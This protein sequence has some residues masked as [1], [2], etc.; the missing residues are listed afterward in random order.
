MDSPNF[1]DGLNGQ[2]NAVKNNV[3][4]QFFEQGRF[5]QDGYPSHRHACKMLACL[6]DS[7]SEV[8]QAGPV[9]HSKCDRVDTH[10]RHRI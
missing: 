6:A 3:L 4:S 9:L 8:G 1:S 10:T 5:R 2:F 7:D